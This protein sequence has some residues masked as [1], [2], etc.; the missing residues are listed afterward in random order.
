MNRTRI[1]QGSHRE[2]ESI[3]GPCAPVI[4]G[5]RRFVLRL[6]KLLFGGMLVKVIAIL[7]LCAL[8]QPVYAANRRTD[9]VRGKLGGEIDALLTRLSNEGYSGSALVARNGKIVLQ[10]GYGL[11]NR[12]RN[13]PNT[14]TTL[15]N[16]A[17]VAKVFTAA[18]ILQLEEK[19]K[20]STGDY[21]SK[22]LGAF[23]NEKGRATIHH[24]LTHTSGLVVKGAT[25]DYGSRKAFIQ[26][27]KDTPAASKPGEK[28]QYLNAG[29]SLLAAIV[30]EASGLTFEEYLR[31]HIFKPA[32]MT[33]TGYV[34]DPRFDNAPAAIGYRGSKLEALRPEPR[35]TDVWSM[36]GPEGLLTTV[37]EL[38]RWIEALRKNKVLSER[39][40]AKM[41][42]AY[43]GDEGY[44]WHV[45]KT[46]RG[47][48]LVNR[49]GG[50]PAW[51]SELRWHTDDNVV[52]IFT[53]NNHLGFRAPVLK[54][55]ERIIWAS[56][57]S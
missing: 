19:A 13:I 56:S 31:K 40:R 1:R 26:S 37:G 4:P 24:L 6:C 29:Y 57:L 51:E 55:I 2:L 30:E 32:G 7:L 54:G 21:I 35:G 48:T 43:V 25:L 44:G 23:P 42:T 53:I 36:R 5:V 34:W 16:V 38:Y 33:S 52:V 12:E 17:S 28:Y 49:G 50:L 27:V 14:S 22:Y 20:L 15:F 10:K 41:F 11:A 45:A 47:G 18:A 3:G 46:A 9:I 8:T 39:A